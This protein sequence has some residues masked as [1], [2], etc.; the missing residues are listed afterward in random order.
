MLIEKSNLTRVLTYGTFDLFHYGHLQ[1]LKRAA[2]LGDELIVG[3]STDQF[4]TIKGKECYYNFKHRAEIVNAIQW[5]D[6][7]I[8][9]QS[10]DQKEKDIQDFNVDILVMGDDWKGHFDD[11]NDYCKIIY[12]P[13][14]EGISTHSIK[15]D[16]SQ[17]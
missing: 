11:L 8:P 15:Q 4:N 3:V 2:Y 12:L 5:V 17:L 7:V 13:R 10:W 14:T 9:E 16:L 6:T 1:I